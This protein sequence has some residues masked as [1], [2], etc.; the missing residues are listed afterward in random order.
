MAMEKLH[1]L[2][3]RTDDRLD[4][5]VLDT[6]PSSNAL[7]FLEAPSKVLA[8]LDNDA[9]RWL[10][11]PYAQ[12]GRVSGKL[13][14]AGSSLVLRTVGRFT[15]M[16]T[17]D[18]LAELLHCF[19][20][21]FD[22]FKQRARAVREVLADPRTVFLIVSAPRPGPLEDARLFHE[23][24]S[25]D[26]IH[27]AGFVLNRAVVDPFAKVAPA[28]ERLREGVA[29][30]G[31]TASLADRLEAV[32]MEAQA[33][34]EQERQAARALAATVPGLPVVLAPELRRD[35]HDLTGLDA[36]RRGLFGA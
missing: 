6:P 36:L 19:Q 22:G 16:E 24:L 10:V 27:L 5:I 29:A 33:L 1:D 8:A 25:A 32:A 2:A 15:G 35:V 23:R 26:K 20:G 34:A 3:A 18:A 4:L 17:L 30:A 13:F 14:D 11:E 7:D 31:G 12:R 9:T 21:M 28:P